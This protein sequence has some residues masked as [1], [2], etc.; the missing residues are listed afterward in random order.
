MDWQPGCASHFRDYSR[1]RRDS[2]YMSWYFAA[3]TCQLGTR[4]FQL[5]ARGGCYHGQR[6][7]Q[8]VIKGPP[9]E[10]SFVFQKLCDNRR[11]T[12][13]SSSEQREA[14]RA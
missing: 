2:R 1:K 8:A 13:R 3:Q 6:S 9:G 7:A 11:D 5:S 12:R 10:S 14:D 4:C